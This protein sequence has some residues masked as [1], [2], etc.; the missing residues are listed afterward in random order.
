MKVRTD[1]G[2]EDIRALWFEGGKL[3]MID[4]RFLPH[5]LRTVEY[6]SCDQVAVAIK[7]MVTRGAT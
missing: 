3:R 5:Q 2:N 1:Y 7:D 6:D 4:Q